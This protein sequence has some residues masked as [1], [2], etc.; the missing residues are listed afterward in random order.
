LIANWSQSVEV[1]EERGR[2]ACVESM[3]RLG[4]VEIWVGRW[5]CLVKIEVS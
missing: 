5:L 2:M 4:M 1:W 3:E